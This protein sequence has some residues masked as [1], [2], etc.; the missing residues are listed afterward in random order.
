[1]F[2][3]ILESKVRQKHNNYLLLNMQGIHKRMVRLQFID[4]LENW[5]LPQMNTNYD[6]YVLQLDGA[7]PPILTGMYECF[8]IVFFNSA[9]LDVMQKE[10]TTFCLGRPVR[11]I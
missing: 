3:T 6:N 9:G 10:T 7:P 8:S 11:W 5:L 2:H 1:M 4:M